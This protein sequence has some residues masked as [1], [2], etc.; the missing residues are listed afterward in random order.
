MADNNDSAQE[1]IITEKQLDE[2]HTQCES[3]YFDEM[4]KAIRVRKVTRMGAGRLLVDKV[5]P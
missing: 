2:L 4:V 5:S 1:Y 3:R